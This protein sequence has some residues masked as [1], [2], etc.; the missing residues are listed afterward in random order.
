MIN[1]V[2]GLIK[3]IKKRRPESEVNVELL[4]FIR[5]LIQA[6]YVELLIEIKFVAEYSRPFPVTYV[7]LD[8][9]TRTLLSTLPHVICEAI[10]HGYD[11]KDSQM[12]QSLSVVPKLFRPNFEA[13]KEYS[14]KEDKPVDLGQPWMVSDDTDQREPEDFL[15]SEEVRE[16]IKQ[17]ARPKQWG[18]WTDKRPV[19]VF[20]DEFLAAIPK[21]SE[22]PRDHSIRRPEFTVPY[23]DVFPS[24][25]AEDS[26][27]SPLKRSQEHDIG[28]IVQAAE[29]ANY[30]EDY[31]LDI[32]IHNS[33]GLG[34]D[35][36]A[37]SG[38]LEG[39][40]TR[41]EGN[42]APYVFKVTQPGQQEVFIPL[43]VISASYLSFRS[44]SKSKKHNPLVQCPSAIIVGRLELCHECGLGPR[45]AVTSGLPLVLFRKIFLPWSKSSMDPKVEDPWIASK[46][47]PFPQTFEFDESL[48]AYISRQ[49]NEAKSEPDVEAFWKYWDDFCSRLLS[50]S[51]PSL[52]SDGSLLTPVSFVAIEPNHKILVLSLP[53]LI[54]ANLS[55]CYEVRSTETVFKESQVWVPLLL[56]HM[57]LST[58]SKSPEAERFGKPWIVTEEKNLPSFLLPIAKVWDW[59]EEQAKSV[60]V[61]GFRDANKVERVREVFQYWYQYLEKLPEPI[62]G[63][64]R[65]EGP[66]E[67]VFPEEVHQTS[68][69][70]PDARA[71]R[72]NAHEQH[73][74]TYV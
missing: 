10:T 54:L 2:V 38:L 13:Y 55:S 42:G 32:E 37:Q 43:N 24:A 9:F 47:E 26:P 22:H 74:L 60:T 8:H 6:P 5:Y 20:C 33:R 35:L 69:F 49:V 65:Y 25:T 31:E 48:K 53:E 66:F 59:I 29:S 28:E 1:D 51:T 62:R 30:D 50:A 4:Q 61:K 18:S 19:F 12:R 27:F 68:R 7:K 21:R 63:Y 67:D 58:W 71:I 45:L 73:L 56:F 70:F 3:E 44:I 57:L 41:H 64:P 52:E 23:H 17:E 14:S 39:L 40:A 11:L 46:T 15:P 34:Q 36:T 72:S 16:W